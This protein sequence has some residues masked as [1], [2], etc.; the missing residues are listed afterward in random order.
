MFKVLR[1]GETRVFNKADFIDTIGSFTR[2]MDKHNKE[3]TL[4]F[5]T[6]VLNSEISG[7]RV[8]RKHEV[9]VSSNTH[10][11]SYYFRTKDL[12][13]NKRIWM[14]FNNISDLPRRNPIFGFVVTN[15]TVE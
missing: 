12:G 15:H 4:V 6:E 3:K 9:D 2:F 13:T 7:I 1:I 11:D 14:R 8:S 10:S 5:I